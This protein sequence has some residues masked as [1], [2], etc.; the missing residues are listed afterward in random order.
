MQLLCCLLRTSA[1]LFSGS[2]QTISLNV[3]HSINASMCVCM[4][5][6]QGACRYS[7]CMLEMCLC[8]VDISSLALPT[9]WYTKLAVSLDWW[10]AGWLILNL[11]F[12]IKWNTKYF[13]CDQKLWWSDLSLL[14][15]TDIRDVYGCH[16][17]S[18]AGPATCNTAWYRH[19]RY[20]RLLSLLYCWSGNL[21]LSYRQSAQSVVSHRHFP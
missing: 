15:D 17:F 14:H 7:L 6:V 4:L 20:V 19:T 16:A 12:L 2:R 21:E 5:S 9:L 3:W 18:V 1:S 13:M 10:V 8:T 11:I